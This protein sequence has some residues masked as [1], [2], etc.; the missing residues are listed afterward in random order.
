MNLNKQERR[1]DLDWL[2]VLAFTMLIFYHTSLVFTNWII[3]NEENSNFLLYL[4]YSVSQ[5]RMPLIC[6]ISGAG[7]FFAFKRRSVA[8]FLGERLRRLLIPLIFGVLF[9]TAPQMYYNRLFE[10]QQ[11]ASYLDFQ[12]SVFQFKIFPKGNFH[13]FHLWF[14]GYLLLY[15][16]LTLPFL[17]VLRKEWGKRLIS[18]LATLFAQKKWLIFALIMPLIIVDVMIGVYWN[19]KGS[20]FL[21]LLIFFVYGYLFFT[22]NQFV[23]LI[24]KYRKFTIIG[25]VITALIVLAIGDKTGFGDVYVYSGFIPFVLGKI[26]KNI[27]LLL[28]LCT[29]VGFA[30]RYLNFN[31][32]IL[33]YANEAV[34]PFYILHQ[35]VLI[36]LG[37]YVIQLQTGIAIKFWLISIGTFVISLLIFELL[38]RRNKIL[39]FL[40]G[41]KPKP[42]KLELKTQQ[43]SPNYQFGSLPMHANLLPEVEGTTKN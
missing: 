16:I 43:L 38:I 35:T 20:K 40:F 29:I 39:R 5:W 18:K 32:S 3:S 1:F 24:R 14:I 41:L 25:A 33:K 26:V 28:W 8:S 13:W 34:Y 23:V 30:K 2:R 7:V 4:A 19:P 27:N 22:K 21:S 9:I 31:H 36:V 15:C 17:V 12:L 11:V 42:P 6:V 10:G 37:Y